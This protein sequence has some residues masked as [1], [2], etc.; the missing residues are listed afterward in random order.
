MPKYQA[1]CSC[2]QLN[3][4]V[5][6]DPLQ[7]FVCHCFDCQRRTGSAFGHQALFEQESVHIEGESRE[8]TQIGDEGFSVTFNFCPCCGSQVWYRAERAKGMIGIPIGAF[9]DADFPA[10]RTSIYESR[11]HPWVELVGDVKRLP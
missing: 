6:A 4:V 7:V 5:Q 2:G 9:A 3:A 11:K 8:Y 10:P 1:R